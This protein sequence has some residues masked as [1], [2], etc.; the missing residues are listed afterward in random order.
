M[1]RVLAVAGD[2]LA[3][4]FA[5]V[6]EIG[7]NQAKLVLVSYPNGFRHEQVMYFNAVEYSVVVRALVGG[8]Q[9]PGVRE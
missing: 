2:D 1:T 5:S 6:A 7:P 4:P 9:A 8:M 3:G